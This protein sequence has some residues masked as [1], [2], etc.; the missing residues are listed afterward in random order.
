MRNDSKL[1][2]PAGV[3]SNYS[4]WMQLVVCPND[5]LNLQRGKKFQKKCDLRRLVLRARW[6]SQLPMLQVPFGMGL[7]LHLRYPRNNEN[8]KRRSLHLT[9]ALGWEVLQQSLHI[10]PCVSK[11]LAAPNGRPP[12]QDGTRPHLTIDMLSVVNG[13]C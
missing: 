3:G 6:I 4:Y 9:S 1:G 5:V 11:L 12:G 10:S 13:S 7:F 8:W 2:L